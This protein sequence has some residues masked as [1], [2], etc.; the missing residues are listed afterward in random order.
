MSGDLSEFHEELRSVAREV[1]AERRRLGTAEETAT[2]DWPVLAA[3]G[4]LGLEVDDTFEGAGA[5]LAE[6]AVIL[7]ELGRS[8]LR[9]GYLGSAVL[10]V[11]VL[12][13]LEPADA[14]DELLRQMAAGGVRLAVGVPTK[15]PRAN[16]PSLIMRL[17]H[18]G[19]FS[20][21]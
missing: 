19:A 18:A 7:H 15:N 11:G 1:L 2:L 14:R 13:L 5:T 8:P 17:K 21:S 9:S 12:N 10:G 16:T 4:W 6:V 20:G 3:S